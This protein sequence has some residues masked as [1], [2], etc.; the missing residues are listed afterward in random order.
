MPQ[1]GDPSY[2][3]RVD[4]FADPSRDIIIDA[5]GLV[6]RL[7]RASTVAVERDREIVHANPS[8]GLVFKE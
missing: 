2:D 1:T 8:P 5:K 6:A 4:A 7:A 3:V